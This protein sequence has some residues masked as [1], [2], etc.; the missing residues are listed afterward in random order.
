MVRGYSLILVVYIFLS[1][2]DS[3][4]VNEQFAENCYT[5]TVMDLCRPESLFHN[6]LI[7]CG[8]MHVHNTVAAGQ[9]TG[10]EFYP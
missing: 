5:M 1:Y 9:A 7:I 4:T 2:T 8:Q 10:C 6:G 3:Y